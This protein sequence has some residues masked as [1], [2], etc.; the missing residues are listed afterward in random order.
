MYPEDEVGRRAG[1]HHRTDD[2]VVVGVNQCLIEI[3]HQNLPTNH[4]CKFEN[5]GKEKGEREGREERTETLP[6]QGRQG[7]D[8]VFD[9]LIL[10]DLNR[11]ISTLGRTRSL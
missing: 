3:Q 2:A 8:I 5:H 7:H 9:H 11:I 4:R 6:G 10:A 1:F